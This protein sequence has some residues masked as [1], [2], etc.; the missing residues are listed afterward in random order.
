MTTSGALTASIAMCTFNGERFLQKQFDSFVAQTVLPGEL[1]VCDDGSTD[2]TLEI[3][4]AFQRTA[5]FPVQIHRNE[6]NL[7]Y[8][9]N[10]EK[11]ACECRH[12][13]VFFSDQ[14]DIWLPEKIA[15]TLAVF[16][17]HPQAGL[18]LLQSNHIDETD[19]LIARGKYRPR[20]AA[21]T[22]DVP[23]ILRKKLRRWV[24][25]WQGC[26]MA[27][28]NTFRDVLYPV[29][30]PHMGH[31]QWLLLLLGAVSEVRFLETPTAL[32]RIHASNL[33]RLSTHTRSLLARAWKNY[34]RHQDPTPLALK[35]GLFHALVARVEDILSQPPQMVA[36]VNECRETAAVFSRFEKHL[37]RRVDAIAHPLRRPGI[38]LSEL[39]NGNYATCSKGLKDALSDLTAIPQAIDA[40][41]IPAPP[42]PPRP[43]LPGTDKAR[44]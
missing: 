27:Y 11:A 21:E 44:P 32:H 3:L 23:F 5:P 4:E 2:G 16:Q 41:K 8:V 29:F 26:N 35:A 30:S 34:R 18:V 12:E 42:A 15:K 24:I 7:G 36:D 40:S 38:I 1:I 17:R 22:E 9:K 13:V 6:T 33:S 19:T 31:D 28:R 14:D 39:L 25:S 20:A 37:A 10:F 43:G